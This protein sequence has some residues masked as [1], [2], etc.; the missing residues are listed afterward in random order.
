LTH[1]DNLDTMKPLKAKDSR[2]QTSVEYL[3]IL[4]IAIVISVVAVGVIAGYIKIGSATTYKR[5]GQVYWKSADIGIMDW[6]IRD[7]SVSGKNSTLMLVNN[8]EYEIHIDWFSLNAGTTTY[9]LDQT[10]LPG[11]TYRLDTTILNCSSGSSYSF[12]LTFQYK[13]VEHDIEEKQF[14]GVEKVTGTCAD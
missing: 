2:G 9:A 1:S 4:A 11:D 7:P 8:R 6:N 3:V 10:L 13:N 12:D 5:K 14:T